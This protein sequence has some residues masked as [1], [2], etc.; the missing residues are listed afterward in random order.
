M[1]S[2]SPSARTLFGEAVEIDSP[3]DRVAFLDLACG[4]DVEMRANVESLLH[5]HDEAGRFLDPGDGADTP[6]TVIGHY[7]LLERIG[8]GG[9]GVVYVAEQTHPIRRQV[10]L[11]MIKPGMD[12]RQVLAR[13]EVERQALAMMDHPNIAKVHDAGSTERGR[14]YFVMELVKGVPVT[15]SCD[16]RRLTVRE[17]L[18]L[19]VTVCHAVQH[20]HQKGVIHRDLKPANVLVENHDGRAMPKVIDF[21]IAKA[22]ETPLTNLTLYTGFARILGTPAYMSP[23]QAGASSL[24][25]DTRSDVYSLGVMLYELLA[26]ATPFDAEKIKNDGI[27]EVRRMIREDESPRPSQR[28]STLVAAV[29]STISDRRCIDDRR[30]TRLLRGDLDWVVMKALE[31]DRT[32]RY[33]SAGAFAFDIERYL[34]N[35][36]VEAR[37]PSATYRLRKFARRNRGAMAATLLLGIASLSVVGAIGWAVR[38]RSAREGEARLADESRQARL[39]GQVMII[40]DEADRLE[41][42]QQWPQALD[43]AR[44]ASDLIASGE[45]D[46]DTVVR[47]RETTRWLELVRL[48]EDIRADK[49]EWKGNSF[50]FRGTAERYSAAFRDGGIDTD[51]MTPGEAADRLRDRPT[52]LPAL[53]PVLDDWATC[54]R[55]TGDEGGAKTILELARLV[56]TDPWRQNVRAAVWTGDKDALL[57]LA[58]GPDLDR[59]PAATL[60]S[61]AVVLGDM[62]RQDVAVTVLSQARRQNPSDFWVHF[63]LAHALNWKR[64]PDLVQ[65]VGSYRAAVGLRPRTAAAWINLGLTLGD[66][67]Q[68]TEAVD[69]LNQAIALDPK[70]VKARNSLGRVLVRDKQV[71]AGIAEIRKAID[72]NPKLPDSHANLGE[73]L[74]AKNQLDAALKSLNTAID[75]DPAYALARYYLGLVLAKQ[76]KRDEAIVA[77]RKALDLDPDLHV[78]HFPLGDALLR[79]NKVDAAVASLQTAVDRYPA[80]AAIHSRLGDAL[81][82]QRK[83]DDAIA[84]QKKAIVLNPNLVIAHN[85]LGIILCDHKKDY[86]AAE[87]A[88]RK[89][90]ELQ[91]T[92][93]YNHFNLGN[94]L[95][96]KGDVSGA[97]ASFREAIRLQP[98]NV[99]AHMMLSRC[100]T[101]GADL[102]LRDTREGLRMAETAVELAPQSYLTW[103]VAGWAH[104]RKGDWKASI[105][106]LEKS[107]ALQKEPQGGDAG[108]WFFLAMAHRQLGDMAEARRWY[109]RAEGWMNRNAR[110][111]KE[112]Q[113][114]RAEAQKVLEIKKD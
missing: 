98:R 6:G 95:H 102:K 41:R 94:A 17:R 88:F 87:S 64:P 38:D 30:L 73:A 7:K 1:R 91:P 3:T 57:A 82:R 2:V 16:A 45:V 19:F 58:T 77:F 55:R 90:I 9:M 37:P 11:K 14:P 5:A 49:S 92:V 81:Y 54:R 111:S 97:I 24:D 83:Y 36:P 86:E 50:D 29:R 10:A 106:A 15:E 44:R 71:D 75:L 85:Q 23:E 32:R 80:D 31:K 66:L 48:V 79:Q 8:E 78:V 69:C 89:V 25:V 46:A 93:D 112:L 107:M 51:R 28:V 114:I 96:H 109:D 70:L 33:E 22:T 18:A 99:N 13:F 39:T 62:R 65:A 113:R 42:D 56:D 61:L 52:M 21:G 40:L 20:A 104:Y 34:L 59:Q 108:Q 110:K 101:T 76:T 60:T 47:M 4:A 72:L 43:T 100:L 68:L 12:T 67:G 63:A 35:E 103:L 74:F 26:G 105:A 27:D 84:C 53:I